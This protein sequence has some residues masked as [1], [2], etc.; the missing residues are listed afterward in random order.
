MQGLDAFLVHLNLIPSYPSYSQWDLKNL[1]VW[2]IFGGPFN[3]PGP[4]GASANTKYL[5]GALYCPSTT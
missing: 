2:C 5:L 1:L 4:I 3:S